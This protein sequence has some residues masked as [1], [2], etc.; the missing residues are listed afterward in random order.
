MLGGGGF[1]MLDFLSLE[2]S[3]PMRG[4]KFL[5]FTTF[6]SKFSLDVGDLRIGAI[7]VCEKLLKGRE[8]FKFN[9]GKAKLVGLV[10]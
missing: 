3:I 8:L 7:V 9:F 6:S 1:M 4:Y 2:L 5:F 10:A